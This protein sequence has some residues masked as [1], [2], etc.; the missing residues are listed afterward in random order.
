MGL[1]PDEIHSMKLLIIT[2]ITGDGF[3]SVHHSGLEGNHSCGHISLK[4]I[5]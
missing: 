3:M 4:D 1:L 5:E 2:G